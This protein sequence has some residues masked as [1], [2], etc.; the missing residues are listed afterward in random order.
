MDIDA[1]VKEKHNKI[2][3]S[4]DV[5]EIYLKEKEE[6]ILLDKISQEFRNN[7]LNELQIKKAIVAYEILRNYINVN[8]VE[9]TSK[10]QMI[11]L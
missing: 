8:C 3:F 7:T 5:L 1:F 10:N 4:N 11:F 9:F 2:V 6:D